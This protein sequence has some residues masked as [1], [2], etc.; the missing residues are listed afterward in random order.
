MSAVFDMICRVRLLQ[1]FALHY[2]MCFLELQQFS[3]CVYCICL[4]LTFVCSLRLFVY[5]TCLFVVFVSF[6][7]SCPSCVGCVLEL[8]EWDFM[9]EADAKCYKGSYKGIQN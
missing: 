4:F 5:C 3:L 6:F 2:T 9:Y 7:L 1:F 8:R